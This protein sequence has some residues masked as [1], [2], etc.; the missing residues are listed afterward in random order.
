MD[1]KPY[2]EIEQEYEHLII[3]FNLTA[4]IPYNNTWNFKQTPTKKIKHP[5]EK[6]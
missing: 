3:I 4:D 5:C 6:P 2:G 1:L